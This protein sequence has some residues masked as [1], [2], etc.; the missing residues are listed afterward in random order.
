MTKEDYNRA[1]FVTFSKFSELVHLMMHIGWMA[2]LIELL[3]IAILMRLLPTLGSFS[4]FREV[5][6]PTEIIEW[7]SLIISQQWRNQID[8]IKKSKGSKADED[9]IFYQLVHSNLP[10]SE[11]S[12][13]RLL[14]EAR[15]IIQAGQDTTGDSSRE[16][17]ILTLLTAF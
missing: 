15:V 8:E 11:K 4:R 3:P 9:T 7:V 1:Y 17:Q 14:Q 10:E 2:S 13:P 16:A 5:N 6:F 12:T